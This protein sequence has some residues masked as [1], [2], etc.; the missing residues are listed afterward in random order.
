MSSPEDEDGIKK[1]TPPH[2]SP[3]FGAHYDSQS[4]PRG[5]TIFFG[6]D[7]LRPLWALL[8]YLAILSPGIL[9]LVLAQIEKTDQGSQAHLGP[10]SPTATAG[11]NWSLFAFIFVA[12]WI[13]SRI[14]HRSVFNYGLHPSL[15]APRWLITGA[16]WGL[17][18]MSLLITILWR[19]HHLL[20][21]AVLLRPL[22]ALGYGF[23]WAISFLGVAF[24]EEF[25]FRGY[26]QSNLTRCFSSLVRWIAPG[27]GSAE[28]VGFWIAA[29]V[30][31]F[32]FGLVHKT[33]PGESPIGLICAGCAGLLFAFSLWRTGSLWWAIGLHFTWDWAQ[34]FLFGV[35]DSG[36]VSKGRLLDSH[37]AGSILM[38][39]G[40][41]GPEGS[42]FVLPVMLL[43]VLV[44]ALTLRRGISSSS[45]PWAG[46]EPTEPA[47]ASSG[48]LA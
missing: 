18:F 22:P 31:S 44:I 33:N 34:S 40:L 38:S 10:F 17:L 35:A 39:G 27:I 30:I 7:G 9:Y 11:T 29:L 1:E 4:S 5:N 24:F 23:A 16:F 2:R 6:E 41:T 15:R 26:L 13:M 42:L 45:L 21:T 20:V 47:G 36:A 48:T 32:G 19:T 14:E 28:A 12:T 43:I 8:L 25:F 46:A 37:P 3:I